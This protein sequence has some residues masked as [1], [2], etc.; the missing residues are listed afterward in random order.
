MSLPLR[1]RQPLQCRRPLPPPR[2][3]I[4]A[5]L[6]LTGGVLFLSLGLSVFYASLDLGGKGGGEPKDR[7]I[8]LLVL[9]GI[10]KTTYPT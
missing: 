4:A 8:A 5:V 3:A 1:A 6:L 9:G 10:S 7:G 2:T